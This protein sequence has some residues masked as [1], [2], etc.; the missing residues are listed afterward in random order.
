MLSNKLCKFNYV[1][2]LTSEG[3]KRTINRTGRISTNNQW[4]KSCKSFYVKALVVY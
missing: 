2:Y 3:S 1:F 4:T